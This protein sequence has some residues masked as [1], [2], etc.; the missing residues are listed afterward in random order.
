MS[1]TSPHGQPA[2][3]QA[4]TFNRE[5]S[6]LRRAIAFL[7]SGALEALK[8]I[9]GRSFFK[10]K[11]AGIR[12]GN[13][14]GLLAG[15][16]LGYADGYAKGRA[17]LEIN[18]LRSSASLPGE[19]HCL[20]DNELMPI[21]DDIKQKMREEVWEKLDK[22]EQ[23]SDQQWAMIFANSTCTS[24]IA[25][26]GSGK[27]TTLA[28]RVVLKHFHLG[29]P[30]HHM[31]VTTFTTESKKDLQKKMVNI[32]KLWG[33]ELSE[34][35]TK[36]LVRT[37]HS[38]VFGFMKT[39][40]DAPIDYF[41]FLGAKKTSDDEGEL[42]N[43]FSSK[44]TTEQGSV[45][46]NVFN[47]L[48]EKNAEFK[49]HILDLYKSIVFVAPDPMSG[50]MQQKKDYIIRKM[51]E[52]D[53]AFCDEIEAAWIELGLWPIPGVSERRTFNIER[54]PFIANGYLPEHDTLVI[55]GWPNTKNQSAEIPTR[56]G[57]S[58]NLERE[59]W[60]RQAMIGECYRGKKYILINNVM[61]AKTLM[62]NHEHMI[63]Q[64]AGFDYHLPGTTIK[65]TKLTEVFF[66][67]GNY[68]ENLGLDVA[69]AIGSLNFVPGDPRQPFYLAL[70]IY[71][72]GFHDYLEGMSPRKLITFNKAFAL[73]GE[74]NPENIKRIPTV[75]LDGMRHLMIDE[76]QDVSGLNVSWV[77]QCCKE[78]RTRNQ[79]QPGLGNSLMA[80][81][82]DWQSIYGWR[83]SSPQYLMDFHE[84]FH[85][86]TCDTLYMQNNYRSH[87]TIIDAAEQIVRATTT[88]K[89]KH[90]IAAN[91]KVM[92]NKTPVYL[93]YVAK[94]K[95]ITEP[96]ET[97]LRLVRQAYDDGHSILMVFRVGEVE[98][99]Y[100]IALQGLL[101]DARKSR[102]NVK[103]MT[104]HK[105]KGLQAQSVFVIGDCFYK[106]TKSKRNDI[107]SLT[108]LGDKSPTP[109]D[110]AQSDEALRLAYVGI[111]RAELRCH[112]LVDREITATTKQS[113]TNASGYANFES[114]C[115]KKWTHQQ[116]S[117]VSA[118][119]PP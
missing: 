58:V 21:T 99:A 112:W 43:P 25:G 46:S 48:Y 67:E 89:A 80:V 22:K 16:K 57:Q 107:Y 14:T 83:G 102:R 105:S 111:T 76:F 39:F 7:L 38:K 98:R 23:P 68:I 44:I 11:E 92:N 75:E 10:G 28:L 27:S 8:A 110:N 104:F 66:A 100:K 86:H 6:I 51:S 12:Q 95:K 113:A 55:L 81:G 115:Y 119:S 91:E 63:V 79:G 5:L 73:F 52:K 42:E 3:Q 69:Q 34:D 47:T 108:N 18:D 72:R 49:K 9:D 97:I 56:A 54:K 96:D 103:L 82:D 2:G 93:H 13:H 24:V 26:A 74:H 35:Q 114:G 85:A 116:T 31:Q 50:P 87:Q 1:Q 65:E 40:S 17:V 33:K 71:W 4:E 36:S 90:G 118:L 60:S 88:D 64:D 61:A 32:F 53:E 37:F 106:P 20:F 15:K 117:A 59:N 70:Q 84:H 19:D 62:G 77:R 45:L 101:N 29:I 109:Y 30:L 78:I 94:D 41:D